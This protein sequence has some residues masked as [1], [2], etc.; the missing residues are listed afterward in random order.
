MLF[1][2]LAW[3]NRHQRGDGRD[4]VRCQRHRA[5][6]LARAAGPRANRW[7]AT[8]EMTASDASLS[9]AAS[10]DRPPAIQALDKFTQVTALASGR[11]MNGRLGL[12]LGGSRSAAT[13][14]SNAISRPRASRPDRRSPMPPSRSRRTRRWARWRGSPTPHSTRK[15]PSVTAT[16][17]GCSAATPI[18]PSRARARRAGGSRPIDSSDGPI[19]L[20]VDRG[21]HEKRFIAGGRRAK[22]L[23]RH[24]LTFGGD[25]ERTS[26]AAA[27]TFTGAIEERVDG[28]PARI[29]HFSSPGLASHRRALAVNVFAADHISISSNITHR[30]L[31]PFRVRRRVDTRRGARHPLAIAAARDL[32]ELG[33]GH[34]VAA[35]PADRRQPMPPIK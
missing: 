6:D 17:G 25:I 30:C 4:A 10:P 31:A 26:F 24:A 14:T 35:A 27:P 3:W 12:V 22:Q 32:H 34:R 20:L 9:Q 28:V 29:W 5:R 18:A 23:T 33:P 1:P 15:P 11:L 7:T 13:T 8:L 21:G 19:G 2:E 16:G